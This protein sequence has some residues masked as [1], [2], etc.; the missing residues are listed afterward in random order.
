MREPSDVAQLRSVGGG[1]RR[2]VAAVEQVGELP[3]LDRTVQRVLALCGDEDSSTADLISALENDAA[4]ALNFPL[5]ISAMTVKAFHLG[6]GRYGLA[7]SI[8]AV[9]SIASAASK[10][11]AGRT[12]MTGP[13]I[14]SWRTGDVTVA[15]TNSVGGTK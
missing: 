11:G 7:M 4:F 8:M 1:D 14:S 3:V 6:A 5:F 13:K 10:L 2:L 9:G 12:A 15:S